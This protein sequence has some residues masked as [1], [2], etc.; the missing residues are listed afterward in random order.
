MK[1]FV[2]FLLALLLVPAWTGAQND[3]LQVVASYSILEDVV[4]NVAG[5]AADVQSLMPVNADP[6]TFEPTPRDLT[7]IAEADIVFTN[8]AFFEE[9]LLASIESAGE[10]TNIVEASACVP[11]IAFEG[12]HSH[13]DEGHEHGEDD[14]DHEGEN[15]EADENHDHE[16][17]DHEADEDHDHGD[18]DHDHEGD[19]DHDHNEE[20]VERCAAH[21]AELDAMHEGDE[22]EEHD[23]EHGDEAL[24]ALYALDC[25]TARCDPHVWTVPH[26][27]MHWTLLIRDTLSEQDPANAEVYAANADAYLSELEALVEDVV[28]PTLAT[29]LEEN[30]VMVTN[31][32]AF[33]YFAHAYDFEIVSTVLPGGGTAVEPSAAEVAGIID[34]LREAGVP[35]VFAENIV[36][37]DLAQQIAR[38]TG[39]EMYQLYSGSLGDSD[40]PAATYIDYITYNVTTVAEALG[41][42]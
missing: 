20:L 18:E 26:N 3:R 16:G 27:V 24:G 11:M 15:H 29:I 41:G 34:T 32:E 4:R 19:E 40:S 13:G 37:D 22:G 6:H 36:S 39:A 9:G 14:H 28:E 42:A 38:E 10:D 12:E 17:E 35:A 5:D 23:H 33:G 25:Q 21:E 30:R 7:A 2:P 1:R 31:H 8:G